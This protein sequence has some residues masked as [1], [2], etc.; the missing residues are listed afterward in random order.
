MGLDLLVKSVRW[1]KPSFCW[2][3]FRNLPR[4][5]SANSLVTTMKV[6]I[7]Q[8]WSHVSTQQSNSSTSCSR[9]SMTLPL[10]ILTFYLHRLLP[11]C[12]I[13]NSRQLGN[14]VLPFFLMDL[15]EPSARP[16]QPMFGL[17]PLLQEA[18]KHRLSGTV[19]SRIWKVLACC[20]RMLKPPSRGPT[21]NKV[22]GDKWLTQGY[23]E[24]GHINGICV[25]L[26]TDLNSPHLEFMW[27]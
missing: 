15:R 8:L 24:N 9:W 12:E 14:K 4:V 23:L 3:S 16:L 20:E 26:T 22:K 21:Q 25:W 5:V 11:F 17:R 7:T 1:I 18:Q 27:L 19:S 6:W 2:N 13:F 10:T